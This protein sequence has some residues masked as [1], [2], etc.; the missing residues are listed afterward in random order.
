M[1]E[2]KIEKKLIS[3]FIKTYLSGVDFDMT[4]FEFFFWKMFLE[5]CLKQ[6]AFL[7]AEETVWKRI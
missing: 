4:L 2:R 5:K 1:R 3:K 7:F 6:V